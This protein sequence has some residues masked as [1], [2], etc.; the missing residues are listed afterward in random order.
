MWIKWCFYSVGQ[1]SVWLL[2]GTDKLSVHFT[3]FDFVSKKHF[4]VVIF[5]N[6]FAV[7]E[8]VTQILYLS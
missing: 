4:L 5:I 3:W 1:S 7:V 8:E 6:L 2:V